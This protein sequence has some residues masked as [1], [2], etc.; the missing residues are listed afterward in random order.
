MK[1]LFP[2]FLSPHPLGTSPRTSPSPRPSASLPSRVRAN[3]D[4]PHMV[5]V[6]F[7]Q[8]RHI[9]GGRGQH[10]HTRTPPK[11][12]WRKGRVATSSRLSPSQVR[13]L[14]AS[15][16]ST[17]VSLAPY[18]AHDKIR[19]PR[20]P[21]NFCTRAFPLPEAARM[22]LPTQP[23]SDLPF[24]PPFPPSLPH[25]GGYIPP[26]PPSP[27]APPPLPPPPPPP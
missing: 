27:P 4:T 23:G 9:I 13:T 8:E 18:R 22:H 2:L 1:C 21:P 24:F 5:A 7:K 25:R 15:I 3:P 17:A 26:Y 19:Q 12:D 14:I 10:I 11:G 20:P 16:A 6:T